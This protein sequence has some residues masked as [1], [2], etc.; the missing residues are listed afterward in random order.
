MRWK[1]RFSHVNPGCCAWQG[2]KPEGSRARG[3]LSGGG[4]PY[5]HHCALSCRRGVA[6]AGGRPPGRLAAHPHPPEQV[7]GGG[8]FTRLCFPP[9]RGGLVHL[10]AVA[11]RRA[12]PATRVRHPPAG[13]CRL[14]TK[15]VGPT[16][17]LSNEPLGP[18]SVGNWLFLCTTT[19][20][21]PAAYCLGGFTKSSVSLRLYNPVCC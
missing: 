13:C 3:S 8:R 19:A 5:P 15:V 7:C 20:W 2:L 17:S 18:G 1:Y 21:K 16:K 12:Q 9:C 14:V 11:R 6:V 4:G 10:D